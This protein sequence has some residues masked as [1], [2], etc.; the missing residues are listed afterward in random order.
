MRQLGIMVLLAALLISACAAADEPL[1]GDSATSPVSDLG[2]TLPVGSTSARTSPSAA[3]SAEPPIEPPDSPGVPDY[4]RVVGAGPRG[5]EVYL[6]STTNDSVDCADGSEVWAVSSSASATIGR[7]PGN[8]ITAIRVDPNADHR[9]AIVSTCPDGTVLLSFA[10]RT[11]TLDVVWTA[12]LGRS[13][14]PL[15]PHWLGDQIVHDGVIFDGDNGRATPRPEFELTLPDSAGQ[16]LRQVDVDVAPAIPFCLEETSAPSFVVEQENGPS[17]SWSDPTN[18]RARGVGGEL[19]IHAIPAS[20]TF[21][22]NGAFALVEY[23]CV[24]DG[25][26]L[27]Q[28]R[29]DPTSGELLELRRLVLPDTFVMDP[30]IGWSLTE[31]QAVR[32]LLDGRLRAWQGTGTRV[33]EHTFPALPF[34]LPEDCF[35]YQDGEVT[36]TGYTARFGEDWDAEDAELDGFTAYVESSL[37]SDIDGDGSS[38]VVQN[39]RFVEDTVGEAFLGVRVCGTSYPPADYVR[40]SGNRPVWFVTDSSEPGRLIMETSGARG[41]FEFYF[42]YDNGEIFDTGLFTETFPATDPAESFATCE[43]ALQG[44]EQI[45]LPFEERIA[46]QPLVSA[47]SRCDYPIF[48]RTISPSATFEFDDGRVG[49]ADIGG[50]DPPP[51]AEVDVA[52]MRQLLMLP[53]TQTD[54]GTYVMPAGFTRECAD[55]SVTDLSTFEALGHPVVDCELGYLGPRLGIDAEGTLLFYIPG[56][57]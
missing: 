8:T 13:S 52:E 55:Y 49:A 35:Q 34:D 4:M 7:V 56:G 36:D 14:R 40:G 19:I 31:P 32:F 5:S 11:T 43:A 51:L 29:Y 3:Q 45:D 57:D 39:F 37:V 50:F 21:G 16:V 24:E 20:F 6:S 30:E 38:D 28:G 9:L 41:Y 33:V 25:G 48:L 53:S 15:P 23:N 10:Q 1:D 26:W 27:L 54:D 22:P 2:T 17:V 46:R 18:W 47:L 12:D 44:P 42:T